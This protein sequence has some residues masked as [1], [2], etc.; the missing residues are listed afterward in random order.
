MG[1]EQNSA[2]L[3]AS[4]KLFVKRITVSQQ[5]SDHGDMVVVFAKLSVARLGLKEHITSD[6]FEHLR[7]LVP[8]YI[9]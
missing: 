3:A 8:S 9:F 1:V 7:R 4:S 2:L 5:L 6:K